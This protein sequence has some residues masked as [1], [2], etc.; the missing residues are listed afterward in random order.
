MIKSLSI[1]VLL[2]AAASS[3]TAFVPVTAAASRLQFSLAQSAS[4][5]AQPATKTTA[6]KLVPPL[7]IDEIMSQPSGTSDLYDENVQKTYG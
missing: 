5:E 2:T 4:T 6:P 1:A 3:A 7:S